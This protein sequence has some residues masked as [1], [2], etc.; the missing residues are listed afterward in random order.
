MGG[1]GVYGVGGPA[2]WHA[3]PAQIPC[4]GQQ[5]PSMPEQACGMLQSVWLQLHLDGRGALLPMLPYPLPLL[6]LP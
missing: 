6:N 2:D 3:Q 4:N 5:L 1:V